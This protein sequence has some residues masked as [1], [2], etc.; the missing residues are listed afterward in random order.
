MLSTQSVPWPS[1]PYG[2]LTAAL[3]RQTN[4][5]VVRSDSL[6]LPDAPRRPG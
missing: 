5:Q 3:E 1:I 4:R 2:K 6:P